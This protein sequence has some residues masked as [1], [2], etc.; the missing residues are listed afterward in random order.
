MLIIVGVLAIIWTLEQVIFNRR[1]CL[2]LS[3]PLTLPG[4]I[5]SNS[6]SAFCCA[7]IKEDGSLGAVVDVNT[8]KCLDD[9]SGNADV[10]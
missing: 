7:C 4:L 1:I 2:G 9:G 10:R 3:C 6:G 5:E 8:Y